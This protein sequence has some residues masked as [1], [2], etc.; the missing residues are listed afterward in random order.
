MLRRQLRGRND[1]TVRPPDPHESGA[2]PPQIP[3]EFVP[4]HVALV[5]DG[6]GR[7]ANM[8]GLS[9]VEGHKRGE[10]VVLDVAK[11]A[12]E[13]GRLK[14]D[15]GNQNAD[16]LDVAGGRQRIDHLARQHLRLRDLLHVDER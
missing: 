6:N 2:R 5:M 12:I 14:A 13:L 3:L 7:W 9:R 15:A 1:P 10:A 16:R 8:R 4:K 11:G